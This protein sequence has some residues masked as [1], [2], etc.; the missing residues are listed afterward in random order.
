M[1]ALFDLSTVL[2]D[3]RCLDC[4]NFLPQNNHRWSLRLQ[5]SVCH[6]TALSFEAEVYFGEVCP[7][8]VHV[9][10]ISLKIVHYLSSMNF[11]WL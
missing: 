8:E 3:T 11:L 6:T 5:S 4:G 1:V 9:K 10:Q 7:P 2:F